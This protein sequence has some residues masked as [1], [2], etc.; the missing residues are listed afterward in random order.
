LNKNRSQ[1]RQLVGFR[2][3]DNI[4]VESPAE[5]PDKYYLKTFSNS[6]K[7]KGLLIISPHFKVF[8]KD[9]TIPLKPYFRNISIMIP[10]PYF[11][12]IGSF[13]CLKK[14]FSFLRLAQESQKEKIPGFEVVSPK[15][16]TL[17][18]EVIRKRNCY[19]ATGNCMRSLQ[20][21]CTHFNLIHAH[22]IENGFIGASVK[23]KYEKPLVVTAHG[24]DAYSLPFRNEWYNALAKYVLHEA[25]AVITV[26][27][28]NKEKLLSLGVSPKSLHVI[29]NGYNDRLF[30][31]WPVEIARRKLGLPL[32]KKILLSVGNLVEVK[33]H[34]YLV[35][36]FNWLRKR[37]DDVLL[38]IV[39]SGPLENLLRKKV[40]DLGFEQKVIFAGQKR[41]E[42]IPIWLN[43][44]NVFVLPSLS[45]G[46]PTVL[47]ESLACGKPIVASNVGAVTEIVKSKE[48]GL[49]VKP[50]S[51]SA[52]EF[53][54]AEALQK[55]WGYSTIYNYALQFSWKRILP[56]IISVY[57]QAC[58]TY[59]Q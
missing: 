28:N 22:F 42:E 1:N 48:I 3:E 38:A 4:S 26:S 31:P 44:C 18:I 32:N 15:Y 9:Q 40:K 2:V 47:S 21:R 34:K 10:F 53:A 7:S 20:K 39:G 58:L 49:L 36:A 52:L 8:I 12:R 45:E 11:S 33:G 6:L 19:L 24:G 30:R 29:P 17:P 16:F 41:H 55:H 25:D 13:P 27:Q 23:Q 59:T 54:L 35:E 14:H 37:N 51:V 56:S 5:V 46:F 50:K 57:E 43:A